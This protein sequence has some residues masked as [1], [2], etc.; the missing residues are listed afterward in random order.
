[1]L[2]LRANLIYLSFIRISRHKSLPRAVGT[3]NG[4]YVGFVSLFMLSHL[5]ASLMCYLP[6]LTGKCDRNFAK[7]RKFGMN[8]V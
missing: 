6:V 3:S 7:A 1:M 2:I 5:T 4:R 8:M